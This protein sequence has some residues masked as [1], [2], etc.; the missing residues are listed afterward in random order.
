MDL[1]ARLVADWQWVLKRSW[2]VRFMV[3]A[4]LLSGCE[5]VLPLYSDLIAHGVFAVLSFIVTAAA[6]IARF[7]AQ[8]RDDD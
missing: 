6:F 3:L 2:S 5:V 7:V 4:A 1:K 8:S